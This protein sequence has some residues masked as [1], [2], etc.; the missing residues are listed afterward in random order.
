MA[1]NMVS[2]PTMTAMVGWKGEGLR[3]RAGC[4]SGDGEGWAGG[5]RP[6]LGGGVW[7]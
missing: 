4:C 3:C 2:K 1:E 5:V 7:P 6:P